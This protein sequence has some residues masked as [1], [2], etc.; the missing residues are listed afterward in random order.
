MEI[1]ALVA[2]GGLRPI[3]ALVLPLEAAMGIRRRFEARH[4]YGKVIPNVRYQASAGPATLK[5]ADGIVIPRSSEGCDEPVECSHSRRP[6]CDSNGGEAPMRDI[7]LLAT[8]YP[9]TTVGFC[10]QSSSCLRARIS[11]TPC[12]GNS[13]EGRRT[14]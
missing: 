1:S 9:A 7:L 13:E 10:W 8:A 6:R 5:E 3:S 11:R 2:Q 4:G 12:G 14:P